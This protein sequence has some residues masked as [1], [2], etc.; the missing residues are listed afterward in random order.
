VCMDEYDG[1]AVICG[2]SMLSLASRWVICDLPLDPATLYSDTWFLLV[3]CHRTCLQRGSLG[4]WTPAIGRHA[5]FWWRL[6]G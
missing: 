5:Q 3:V 1:M 4:A 2:C 6:S